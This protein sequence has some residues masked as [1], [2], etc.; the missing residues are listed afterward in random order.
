MI[1]NF[2]IRRPIFTVVIFLILAIFGYY[3]YG[4]MPVRENPEVEF[5]VVSINVVLPGAE[6]EVVEKEVI[7]PIEEEINTIEG[8]KK[9]VSTAR[10]EVATIT[11][12]FELWRKVDVAAQDVRDRLDRARRELPLGIE[13]PLIRKIDPEAR[14]IMWISLTGDERWDPVR[15]T[16]YADE[17][18][19]RR[20]ESLRG[21]GRIQI[22]GERMFAVRVRLE[23]SKLAAHGVTVQD[24]VETIRRNNVQI[25]SGRIE[26]RQR[27]FLVKTKGRF[28]SA[29]PINDLVIVERSGGIVRVADVGEAVD[30][31]ENERSLARFA[32]TPTVGLGVVKQQDANTVAL[33]RAVRKKMTGLSG[34]FP[35]G[36][37]YSI[38]SDNS[39]YIARSIDDLVITIFVATF[40]VVLVV[41]FF[42]RTL[43]ATFITSLTIPASLLGGFAVAQA[44]G[45]SLNGL[46]LLGFI[47]AIGI[48]IDDSIVVLE[49]SYRHLEEGEEAMNATRVGTSEVA[50]PNIANTLSLAAVFLPV[51]FT[52][53]LIGRF[54]FEFSITVAATVAVSTFTAL[55]LTPM[56]CSRLLRVPVHP[57]RAYRVLERAFNQDEN[58]FTRIL[59]AA[60]HRRY[61]TLM[62]AAAV[63]GAGGFFFTR[64]QTEFLPPID[65]SEFLVLFET[66]EGSSLPY[67]DRFARGLEA[68]LADTP[69]VQHQFLAVGL[70]F[71]GPGKVNEGMAFVR[72]VDRRERKRH[73]VEIMQEIRER[74][75]T[76]P[77]GRAYVL[78]LGGG[79][80]MAG[81][82]LQ[83][84]LQHSDLGELVDRQE[85]IL[86]WMRRQPE[87]IGVNSNLKMNK[88]QIDIVIDRDKASQ[89]GISAAD[90][91]DTFRFFLGDVDISEVERENERY[92]LI[93]ETAE[94]GRITPAGLLDLYL[95]NKDGSL[96]RMANLVE[97]QEAVGPSEIHHFNRLRAATLSASTAPGVVLGN[98]LAKL[99]EE[100]RRLPPGFEYTFTGQARD[101]E[102]SFYYLSVAIAMAAVFIY[103]VLAA[104]F[105]SFIH[106]LS[107]LVTLPLA[108]AGAFG[109]LW[110]LGMTLNI[111][112]FIGLIMLM[113]MVT[114]NA[115]LLV[116]YSNVLVLR[117]RTV[118]A[119][120][121]EA[122]RIRFRPVLMTAFS[123]V[124][125]ILPIALGWGAGG[126]A[127]SPLGVTVV[128]GLL[129]A[130]G[131]T[132]VIIPVVYTLFAEMNQKA[133]ALFNG[134][135]APERKDP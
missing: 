54:F 48:L 34:N 15:I 95:R 97:T 81:A 91:A 82:P 35:P 13:P 58:L 27:E 21:V 102:E 113:G 10:E 108:S 90:I 5:P 8:L 133:S 23:P 7:N 75:R 17:V 87:F 45:F 11:A 25:P 49:S 93:V 30:G 120:A 119:A 39:V 52:G 50:F 111:V 56:L 19:K 32:G 80:F 72:L 86:S 18:L 29:A 123:T 1:W 94:K 69:E 116:D 99:E 40:L 76:L 53:G 121:K 125:G 67:T 112:S 42:L 110:V 61:L 12:E 2:S 71:G 132:L 22:G 47:L 65:R 109:A 77:Q 44:L 79:G 41:L 20:L 4:Q 3:G 37:N 105:E 74:F 51:A 127:R 6:P 73:Q 131:L 33:A 59:N 46:T 118:V 101:F 63:L 24:V 106:P 117:G 83:L 124:M 28:S 128:F 16:R 78:E 135:G 62:I 107:I 43:R 103:L 60:F 100:V 98:A 130:T 57:G 64:L 89:M 96:V 66:P 134:G 31:I 114:K 85:E 14:A 115:I 36:L 26:S 104:Q 84:V 126:E 38:A 88:P 55:T 122:A 68:I 129:A 70:S 9:L 92:E